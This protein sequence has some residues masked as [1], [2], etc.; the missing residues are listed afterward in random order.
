MASRVK[1]T[2][3]VKELAKCLKANLKTGLDE[4]LFLSGDMDSTCGSLEALLEDMFHLTLRPTVS[5]LTD[6]MTFAYNGYA[7]GNV[8][9]MAQAVV[10]CY[11]HTRSK[12]YSV[13][14]GKKL[15]EPVARLVS[16]LRKLQSRTSDASSAGLQEE[17]QDSPGKGVP[18]LPVAQPTSSSKAARSKQEIYKLYGLSSLQVSPEKTAKSRDISAQAE[19][20]LSSAEEDGAEKQ[21]AKKEVSAASF[22]GGCKGQVAAVEASFWNPSVERYVCLKGAEQI[23]L[24]PLRLETNGFCVTRFP[25]GKDFQTEVPNLWLS[26]ASKGTG[27]KACKRPAAAAGGK[28][29]ACKKGKNQE[30]PSAAAAQPAVEGAEELALPPLEERRYKKLYYSA[31][32]KAAI[33]QN[34]S[35]AF[36]K[37][38]G[39]LGNKDYTKEQL[40]SICDKIIDLLLQGKLPESEVKA[41]MD[42]EME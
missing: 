15:S 32:G 34:H 42:A 13:S 18:A 22:A 6:A 21:T 10:N 37:Q 26:G 25:G 19:M 38:L 5:I 4:Q 33:R 29:P 14:T 41:T 30:R 17:S 27:P 39:Q 7:K 8:K 35:S 23:L 2:A 24:E 31:T 1:N 3:S 40:Y 36:K 12:V 11:S 16:L 20:V 9:P 28:E